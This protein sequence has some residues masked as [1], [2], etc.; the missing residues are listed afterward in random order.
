MP[1]CAGI[2]GG[3]GDASETLNLKAAGA[4][5]QRAL[6]DLSTEKAE[7]AL[8]LGGGGGK[9]QREAAAVLAAME[10]DK[11]EKERRMAQAQARKEAREAKERGEGGGA[12]EGGGKE[13]GQGKGKEK[14]KKG[15]PE[16][17][18]GSSLLAGGAP[19][20]SVVDAASASV[21][22]RSAAAAKASNGGKTKAKVAAY[23][24]GERVPVAEN[25][26]WVSLL[27]SLTQLLPRT[28]TGNQVPVVPESVPAATGMCKGYRTCL[29]EWRI[30]LPSFQCFGVRPQVQ[31]KYTSGATSRSFT[32]TTY[33]PVTRTEYQ[34]VQVEKNPTKKGYCRVHTSLGDLNLELHCDLAPRACENFLTLAARGYYNGT[35]FHRSIK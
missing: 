1:G 15:G 18:S 22:G 8:R 17:S 4:A 13:E 34:M 24:A 27:L 7:Q 28:R 12:A 21:A 6:K 2:G 32:S 33:T 14:G 19:A 5:V 25:S 11:A 23:A 30:A 26:K 35:V 16:G 10:R 20:M 3:A 29:Q 9:A 31:S